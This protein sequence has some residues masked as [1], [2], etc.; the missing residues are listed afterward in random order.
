MLTFPRINTLFNVLKRSKQDLV[1]SPNYH[2][3]FLHEILNWKA[4]NFLCNV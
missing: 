3:M 2:R 1:S 4:A